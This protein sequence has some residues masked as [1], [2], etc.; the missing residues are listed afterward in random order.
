M[1]LKRAEKKG[2][3][4]LVFGVEHGV[5][6]FCCDKEGGKEYV[7]GEMAQG[8]FPYLRDFTKDGTYG[9]VII[10]VA[11][12]KDCK[13]GKLTDTVHSHNIGSGVVSKGG[14][15]G[16]KVLDEPPSDADHDAA[17][18]RGV[19]NHAVIEK[20]GGGYTAGIAYPK[21]K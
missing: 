10:D 11:V 15:E 5:A 12:P 17:N 20:V 16:F 14:L 1:L 18:N 19:P 9:Q 3:I 8:R 7:L 13:N 6:V 2:Y 4:T 21:V